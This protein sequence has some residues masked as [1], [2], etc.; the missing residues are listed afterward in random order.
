[1]WPH[2]AAPVSTF[3][4]PVTAAEVVVRN[5][6]NYAEYIGQTLG[7]Q[8]VEIRARVA[9]FLESV[10]FAEGTLVKSN[11]LLYTIDSGPIQ[12]SLEQAEGQ[13][14]QVEAGWLKT[15]QDT[16]RFGPLWERHAISR[17][18]Y[19]DAIAAERAAAASVKAARAAVDASKL[20]LGYT[21]IFAPIDGTVGKIEV[22]P[23]NLVG[24]GATTHEPD[25]TM[26]GLVSLNGFNLPLNPSTDSIK[27]RRGCIV[28][29]DGMTVA[30]RFWDAP[31]GGARAFVPVPKSKE[32]D[33]KYILPNQRGQRH[34]ALTSAVQILSI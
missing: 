5:A 12:A 3:A 28:K 13:F 18:Q 31:A 14:A 22:K 16:N 20:Q 19:D 9:G 34:R 17:Q 4:V 33:T 32:T 7:G 24:Q 10:N 6:T 1:M 11:T 8:D 27:A 15:Q 26:S 25:T 30:S 29:S 2:I 23:G 21:R